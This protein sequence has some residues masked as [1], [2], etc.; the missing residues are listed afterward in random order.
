MKGGHGA[1]KILKRN[2]KT[3]IMINNYWSAYNIIVCILYM[4]HACSLHH[5]H[6]YPMYTQLKCLSTYYNM[7][8]IYVTYINL[9]GDFPSQLY[10]IHFR[11]LNFEHPSQHPA[12]IMM[13]KD[14]RGV[15]RGRCT[16]DNCLCDGYVGGLEGKKCHK[17]THPPGRHRNLDAAANGAG[18][19]CMSL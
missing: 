14:S 9:K 18:N 3:S 12:A 17:C 2:C 10:T 6:V 7:Y 5:V 19:T 4:D 16:A 11:R 13:N 8:I 15:T 1:N